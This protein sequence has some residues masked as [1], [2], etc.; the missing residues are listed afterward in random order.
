MVEII[1][2]PA[3]LAQAKALMAAGVDTIYAGED[4]FGLRLPHSFE[5]AELTALIE[6]VH[7][8]QK[9]IAVAVN[10]I[11]HNDR[12]V[13]VQ[14]YL[15]F[16]AAQKVDR[17]VIGDPGAIRILQK[18]GLALDYWYDSADLVTNSQQVN[19]WAHH[20]AKGA[21]IANEVPYGEL[22]ALVPNLKIPIQMLVYGAA[23][24]H[25]SGRPLL[26]NY[27]NFVKAHQ[28]RLDRQKGLFISEPKKPETHYSIYEDI[29]GTHVF[30]NNDVDL[31]PKLNELAALPIE[32]WY[33]EG[34]YADDAGFVKIAAAFDQARQSLT[35]GPLTTDQL[36]TLDAVIQQ[37]QPVNRAVDTG[38]FEIDPNDVK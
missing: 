36:Q 27:F 11:F 30:A 24:I 14:N 12:I 17:V 5:R 28:D 6:L 15:T 33:L 3:S 4:Y 20:Q 1:A 23:A 25:Q 37:N 22:Q 35:Q 10:A 26:T 32:H 38:F 29:N 16:L 13:H 34:L 8:Q 21:M 31:M 7:S 19:F 9:K 18:S 2:S